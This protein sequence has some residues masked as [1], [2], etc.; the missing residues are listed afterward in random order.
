MAWACM[1]TCGSGSLV[2]I[3]YVTEDGSSRIY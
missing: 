3:D 1:A 2:F